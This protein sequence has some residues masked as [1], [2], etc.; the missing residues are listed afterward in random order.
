MRV[1]QEYA[2]TLTE[3]KNQNIKAIGEIG[4]DSD[5]T[6]EKYVFLKQLEIAKQSHLPVI[7]HTPKKNKKEITKSIIE[8]LD[9]FKP[10]KA[11]IDH[12]DAQNF[13]VSYDSEYYLG[14]TMQTGKLNSHIA[15]E[16]INSYEINNRVILNSDVCDV[17]NEMGG[18]INLI[19][20]LHDKGFD[21]INIKKI[22]REN[23]IKL[24]KIRDLEPLNP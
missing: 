21:E 23:T 7:V 5:S 11:V 17:N 22:V 9:T 13:L 10:I 6:T 24:F 18:I 1:V 8:I 14:F 3:G 16:L 15:T 12:I 19:T 2:I 4:I 20:H